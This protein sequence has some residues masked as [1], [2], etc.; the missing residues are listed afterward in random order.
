M[1]DYKKPIIEDEIIEIEDIIAESFG[2][3]EEPGQ[4]SEDW[5]EFFN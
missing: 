3:D 1:K 4:K 2:T 5:E